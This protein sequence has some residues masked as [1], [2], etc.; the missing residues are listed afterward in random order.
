MDRIGRSRSR[1]R[2]R[3][4]L[5]RRDALVEIGKLSELARHL[6]LAIGDARLPARGVGRGDATPPEVS[7][8]IVELAEAT[9]GLHGLLEDEDAQPAREAAVRAASLANAVLEETGNMSALSALIAL[10]DEGRRVGRAH[11]WGKDVGS[12]CAAQ[13]AGAEHC[14]AGVDRKDGTVLL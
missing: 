13:R 3:R 9:R 14:S 11:G 6:R 1:G 2:E 8:S 10:L 5:P 7:A 12:S 4:G